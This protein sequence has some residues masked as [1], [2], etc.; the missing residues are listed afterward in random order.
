MRSH[1][2]L[3][4]LL[5]A[6]FV[7]PGHWLA[8]QVEPKLE[9]YG[10]LDLLDMPAREREEVVTKICQRGHSKFVP[11]LL[12][13]LAE[14]SQMEADIRRK[15]IRALEL[16]VEDEHVSRLKDMALGENEQAALTAI[17][18]CGLVGSDAAVGVLARQLS[19]KTRAKAVQAALAL[20]RSRNP[21]RCLSFL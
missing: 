5:L 18:L 12:D 4:A 13:V 7:L 21:S 8:A 10:V 15:V 16:T 3:A 14:D 11:L 1:A 6:L 9:D 17:G 20:G 19:S 2:N